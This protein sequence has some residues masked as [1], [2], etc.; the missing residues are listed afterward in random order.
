M[1]KVESRA[2]EPAL[3]IFLIDGPLLFTIVW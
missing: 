2:G 1:K 3:D